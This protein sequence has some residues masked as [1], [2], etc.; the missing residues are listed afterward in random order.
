ML[1]RKF[2]YLFWI[3]IFIYNPLSYIYI[4]CR[5]DGLVSAR[6]A[7]IIQNN[8]KLIIC[9]LLKRFVYILLVLNYISNHIGDKI[10][11]I[12]DHCVKLCLFTLYY[13]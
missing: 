13:V 5:S 6:G 8:N 11:A 7:D 9:V 4:D 2:V 12:I 1:E 3:L 10:I